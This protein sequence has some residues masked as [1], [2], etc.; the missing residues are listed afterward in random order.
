MQQLDSVKK[1][2]KALYFEIISG[3]VI[4]LISVF[5][6]IFFSITGDIKNFSIFYVLGLGFWIGWI[7]LSIFLIGI[8]IKS[9]YDEK[10][11]EL[12]GEQ[13]KARKLRAPM[14]S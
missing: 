11:F 13:K 12:T 1:E 7:G 5:C 10:H 4:S 3:I 6:I 2:R 8:G 14:V 9:Y